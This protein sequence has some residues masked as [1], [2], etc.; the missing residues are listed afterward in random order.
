MIGVPVK[1]GELIH[2]WPTRQ[3]G[4][5]WL[6][7]V[8]FPKRGQSPVMIAV[9]VM[10]SITS[11]VCSRSSWWYELRT[12][13]ISNGDIA[14]TAVHLLVIDGRRVT[15]LRAPLIYTSCSS[16]SVGETETLCRLFLL[17]HLCATFHCIC[18]ILISTMRTGYEAK[19][20]ETAVIRKAK[21]ELP[22]SMRHLADRFDRKVTSTA[23]RSGHAWI[24]CVW[25]NYYC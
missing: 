18:A 6:K 24:A 7:A 25:S 10:I 12:R 1:I 4:L 21:S 14:S 16:L 2:H 15:A 23:S 13:F 3:Y 22:N 9:L 8:P 19:P 17:Q 11:I 20:K 5:R